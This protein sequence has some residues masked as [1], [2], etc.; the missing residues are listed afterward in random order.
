MEINVFY[1]TP[2]FN[3]TFL[4]ELNCYSFLNKYIENKANLSECDYNIKNF[5]RFIEFARTETQNGDTRPIYIFNFF[6]RLDEASD[7]TQFIDAL[8]S[9]GRQVFVGIPNNYPLERFEN[10][11]VQLV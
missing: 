11:K 1:N 5:N 2:N 7:I 4:D 6:E 10:D 8:A 9:F 3:E